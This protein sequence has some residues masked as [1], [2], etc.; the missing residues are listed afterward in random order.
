MI[1][2]YGKSRANWIVIALATVIGLGSIVYTNALVNQLLV[3][4]NQQ[5]AIFA[6][7]QEYVANVANPDE[8]INSLTDI[9]NKNDYLPIILTDEQDR[10]QAWRNVRLPARGDTLAFLRQRIAR[11]RAEHPP[12]EFE[13][14]GTKNLIYYEH[15]SLVSQLRVYPYIQL[16]VTFLFFV[17][18][19]VLFSASRKAEQNKVWVGLAKET[20]HQLGTPISS[21]LAWLEYFKLDENFD[22]SIVGELEKD[23]K[24]LE[25]ITARFSSI[26]SPPVLKP[27]NLG[28]I[29]TSVVEYLE[30]RLSSK[31]KINVQV[32][33]DFGDIITPLNQPLFEWV[34]ENICK[35][36]VDAMSGAGRIDIT[37]GYTKEARFVQIDFKDT[38]KGIPPGMFTT[39]KRGWGL[40]LTLV[41]RI[42][43]NYHRG[44]IFVAES[45]AEVGTTFRVLLPTE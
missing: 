4:E 25:M 36:A 35:N 7:I 40:G 41:K 19:Y 43:E 2:L 27:E 44:K 34:V 22:Q 24:R 33:Q 42:V 11:M 15:S 5:T 28:E 10:P 20:A 16:G 39:K 1:S 31:V 9:I 45:R 18:V 3:Q 13:V 38:G 23:V 12:I 37:L 26:G 21:L 29:V 6:D 8:N 32:N 14:A 30:K 17:I